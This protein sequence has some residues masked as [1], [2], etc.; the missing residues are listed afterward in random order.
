MK[1][2]SGLGSNV[3]QMWLVKRL[4]LQMMGA[5]MSRYTGCKCC[6]YL[7]CNQVLEMPDV[8]IKDQK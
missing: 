8:D 4:D 1:V 3:Q 6:V 2:Q 7:L 5:L